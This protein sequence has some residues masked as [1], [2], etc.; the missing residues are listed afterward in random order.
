MAYYTRY[1]DRKITC[2]MFGEILS[3]LFPMVMSIENL[4]AGFRAIEIIPEIAFALSSLSD[5]PDPNLKVQESPSI[6]G[7]FITQKETFSEIDN[8]PLFRYG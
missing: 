4:R 1:P 2:T 7:V 8:E 6:T 3:V 5:S